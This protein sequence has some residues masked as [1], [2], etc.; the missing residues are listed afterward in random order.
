MNKVLVV[1]VAC[2]C[3]MGQDSSEFADG[4]KARDKADVEGLREQIESARLAGSTAKTELRL[5]QLDFYLCEAAYVQGKKDLIRGAAEE[6]LAA[7]EKA[8][9][10]D[11]ASSEAHRL[12][13]DLAAMLIPYSA[14]GAAKY[15]ARTSIEAQKALD[16]DPKNANACMSRGLAY[17]YTPEAYGGS[18]EKGFELVKKAAQLFPSFD[19]P[20][21]V[22]SQ[23]YLAADRKDDALR[24][25]SE[26]LRLNPDR[27]YSRN[28]YQQVVPAGK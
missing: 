28:A 15:G 18:R 10:L 19:T 16:L 5:A 7:A 27:R 21:L 14:D 24:E 11:P 25:I 9:A 20:H 23:M 13:S 6:G 2:L 12:Q 4:R 3:G 1:F 17:F 8:A 26:A 22:L